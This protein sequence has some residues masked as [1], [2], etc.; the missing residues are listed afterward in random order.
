MA[1]PEEIQKYLVKGQLISVVCK[2]GF[3]GRGHVGEV[4]IAQFVFLLI[5]NPSQYFSNISDPPVYE[6]LNIHIDDLVELKAG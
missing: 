1:T 5:I 6:E 3:R 4:G 2:D